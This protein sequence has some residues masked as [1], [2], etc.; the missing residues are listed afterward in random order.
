M[1]AE[2]SLS[3]ASS[4]F[5]AVRLQPVFGGSEARKQSF[6]ETVS[7]FTSFIAHGFVSFQAISP[8]VGR[9]ASWKEAVGWFPAGTEIVE[10]KGIRDSGSHRRDIKCAFNLL[11]DSCRKCG[12]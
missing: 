3:R 8:F 12:T 11:I 9:P 6:W 1:E 4:G 7:V 10:F 5:A 2:D